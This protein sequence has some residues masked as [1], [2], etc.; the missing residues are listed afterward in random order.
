MKFKALVLSI[1]II[2]MSISVGCNTKD[3]TDDKNV[4]SKNTSADNS[5]SQTV[6]N[7]IVF[8]KFINGEI[9]AKTDEGHFLYIN[10]F[11]FL[12]NGFSYAFF[13]VDND[14]IEELCVKNYQ[15]Y[16]F[17]VK[18]DD[19]YNLYTV[20]KVGTK[21]LNDGGFLCIKQGGEPSHNYYDYFTINNE[22][23]IETNIWFS[24][25][26]AHTID[27]VEYPESFYIGDEE[28]TKEEYEKLSAQYLNIG[29][30]K[31]V[32]TVVA[33]DKKIDA[34][35]NNSDDIYTEIENTINIPYEQ[36][37][38]NAVSTADIRDVHRIYSKK[39]QDLSDKYYNELI[40]IEKIKPY[41]IKL[42]TDWDIY[43]NSQIE[44]YRNI[45]GTIFEG[46]SITGIIFDS[47]EMEL[48]KEWAMQLV[49]IYEH[50]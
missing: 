3:V 41:I 39:W 47:R 11:E 46:G 6:D 17:D 23:N 50:C 43:Y 14:D 32:W 37:L 31:V 8:N 1:F 42:K 28:V 2:L 21:L 16:I 45:Y 9:T 44:N 15:I 10:Q 25:W 7:T 12:D 29:D 35:T 24:W 36:A 22:S 20:T 19:I 40:K 26:D 27:G 13:D 38:D 48:Q 49:D 4:N 34:S 33:G 18:D 5:A 30:D